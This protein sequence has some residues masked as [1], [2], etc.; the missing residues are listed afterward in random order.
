MSSYTYRTLKSLRKYG[1]A[2]IMSLGGLLFFIPESRKTIE[3]EYEIIQ[4][5][6]TGKSG[7]NVTKEEYGLIVSY[8]SCSLKRTLSDIG[9]DYDTEEFKKSWKIESK[10]CKY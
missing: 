4:T 10:K 1:V 2:G 8:C 3:E 6:V 7:R 9:T 5:C